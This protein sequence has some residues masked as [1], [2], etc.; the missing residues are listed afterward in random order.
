MKKYIC[1]KKISTKSLKNLNYNS[2]KEA[3]YCFFQEQR[4]KHFVSLSLQVIKA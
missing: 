1:E 4:N 2:G 3:K